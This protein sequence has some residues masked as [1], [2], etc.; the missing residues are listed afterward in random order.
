MAKKAMK[1]ATDVLVGNSG[2]IFTFTPLTNAARNWIAENVQAE[3]WQWLGGALAVDHHFARDLA[4]GMIDSGLV[5][6]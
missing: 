5:V 3:S 1:A 2:S 4:Q 6:L